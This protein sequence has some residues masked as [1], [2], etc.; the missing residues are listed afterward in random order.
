MRLPR[1]LL[2][3]LLAAS[4]PSRATASDVR[5]ELQLFG[6]TVGEVQLSER[7]EDARRTLTYRSRTRVVRDAIRLRQDA[8]IESTYDAA[9]GHL[10]RARSQRC[11]APEEQP[12]RRTCVPER[13]H[14]P[15]E[16]VASLAAE[17]VL[18]RGTP[19]E[20]RCID[21]VDEES[22]TRGRACARV[23]EAPD[24]GRELVGDKLGVAFRARV[25]DGR[26][27]E[28]ELPA[29][30]A[31]FIE[32]D[33]PIEMSQADLFAEAIPST[34]PVQDAL[35]RGRA[36][37]WLTA[38]PAALDRVAALDAPGQ[39]VLERAANSVKL[40][41][42]QA[43]RSKSSRT[44]ALLDHAALLVAR[45]KGRHA[46]CQLATSWFLEQAQARRWK[47]RPVVGLAWVD[48]RFAF[49]AWVVL[50]TPDGPVPIDPLLAQVPADAGHVQLA[51]PGESA[52]TLLVDFRRGLSLVVE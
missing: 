37:L 28:L 33:G 40:E 12:E 3:V 16:A 44:R 10:V 5:L 25:R 1:L 9:T 7:R 2:P 26:L 21:V 6:E 32:T 14:G 23:I 15:A 51:A 47:A 17:L 45:A 18:A 42:T 29:Q 22:G 35:R 34:G 13:R 49:H 46:D 36:V 24:G 39:Q 4:L 48:G 41:V 52:G 43:P 11:S 27:V 8:F 20:E 30:G 38:P 31:R 19:D 50:D